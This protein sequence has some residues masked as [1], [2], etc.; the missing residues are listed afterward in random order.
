M[1]CSGHRLVMDSDVH[2]SMTYINC[3]SIH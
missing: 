1:T 3:G 2:Y